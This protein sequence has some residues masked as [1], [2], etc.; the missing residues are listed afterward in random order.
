ML[1]GLVAVFLL[2]SRILFGTAVTAVR[3]QSGRKQEF[4]MQA[5]TNG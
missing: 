4:V 3:I 1:P 2:P 5:E